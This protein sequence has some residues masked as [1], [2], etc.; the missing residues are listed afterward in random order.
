MSW[1]TRI[2]RG[3]NPRDEHNKPLPH[4]SAKALPPL[5]LRSAPLPS[6]LSQ[7][8]SYVFDVVRSSVPKIELDDV[9]TTKEQIANSI[10]ESLQDA[11]AG[12]G[13]QIINT[14]ITDIEPDRAVKQ[15]MNEINKT[16]RLRVAAEDEGEANKIRA[17]KEAEAEASRIEIQA[18][19]DAEA[20]FLAGQGISRQRQAIMEGLRESV[21][22]FKNEVQGVDA[23]TVMDL[24]I[25]TQYFDMMKDVGAQG[26]TAAVFMN[27]GGDGL[28]DSVAKGF[29]SGLPAAP[30][31]AQSMGR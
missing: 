4:R 31:F 25:V 3:P 24:M 26:K 9:F 6:P 10:T 30:G 15:A 21:N 2:R 22:A 18:K 16:K 19:A 12:F 8:E 5:T 23:K 1:V 17:V 13:Y 20:K 27:S 28:T 11:M 7:I 14:P 29:M